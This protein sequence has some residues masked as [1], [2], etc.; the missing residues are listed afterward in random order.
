M[1]T[2]NQE[3]ELNLKRWLNVCALVLLFGAGL[4]SCIRRGASQPYRSDPVAANPRLIVL[5]VVDQMRADFLDRLS[6]AFRKTASSKDPEGLKYFYENGTVFLNARTASAP[7]VTAAGHATVCSGTT[8]SK[9]G[10]IA[11]MYFDRNKRELEE[12]AVDQATKLV[13]TPGILPKDPLSQVETFG[14]SDR[15]LLTPNLADALHSWSGGLSRAVSISIKNR[16]SVYCGG[17]HA[18]GVYWYDY[19][20]GSMV[21]SSRYSQL[22]PEWVNQFNTDKRPNFNYT[23]RPSFSAQELKSLLGETRY[24][25]ALDV[26]SALSLKFGKG[27]PYAYS[28]AEIGAI[29]ARKFFEY[30]PAASDHLVDFALEA[31][32]HERLGC[33]QKDN[34]SGCGVP[35]FPDLLTLS[36][37]TPDLV[38]HGFGPESIEH[39]DIYINLNK[40]IER[41]RK[42]LESRMGPGS[43]LFVQTSDHGVQSLPEVT[44]KVSGQAAGRLS[45]NELKLRIEAI[46]TQQYGAGPWVDAVT[47]GQI[48]FNAGSLKQHNRDPRA[49]VKAIQSTVRSIP[50][51]RDLVSASDVLKGGDVELDLYNRGLN[52]DRSGDAF[53]LIAEGWLIEDSVAGNHGTSNDADTHIPMMFSGWRIPK[54]KISSASRA[55]DVAPTILTLIGSTPPATMTGVSLQNAILKRVTK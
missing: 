1:L 27:F 2:F 29:G 6:N 25:Q 50:G 44:Q 41:L 5:V 54:Q 49:L 51:I 31:Q 38:G 10:I 19:Q 36:F 47:N 13:R 45:A 3:K 16:G 11:N 55:D 12:T 28:S 7:T 43:V 48:Y 46:I 42:E 21:T 18:A 37:S 24:K 53:F 20:S 40:S 39:F 23:W 30:T 8:A 32:K 26:R 22:L 4:T 14:S 52:I 34:G 15:R 35:L 17:K 9:H 33:A